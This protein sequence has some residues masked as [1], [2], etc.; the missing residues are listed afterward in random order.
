M[1]KKKVAKKKQA[2]KVAT[3]KTPAKKVPP[4]KTVKRPAAKPKPA[5]KKSGLSLPKGTSSAK[6]V[7]VGTK[8]IQE[9]KRKA[10]SAGLVFTRI[11]PGDTVVGRFLIDD[12]SHFRSARRHS[13]VKNVDGSIKAFTCNEGI[14]DSCF[15][16]NELEEWATTKTLL[17]FL[18]RTEGR[19]EAF[20]RGPRD[21]GQIVAFFNK[22]GTLADRDF[23][24]TRQGKGVNDTLYTFIPNDPEELD[25][26]SLALVNDGVEE[27]FEKINKVLTPT[28]NDEIRKWYGGE[29]EDYVK[30]D[31]I[32]GEK[33]FEKDE[34]D[35]SEKCVCGASTENWEEVE[36]EDG[37]KGYECSKCERLFDE[38]GNE[39]KEDGEEGGEEGGTNN[40]EILCPECNEPMPVDATK[41]PHC[42]TEFEDDF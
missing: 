2:K 14:E 1:A 15:L 3:K 39:V 24:A 16:C 6:G 11:D 29:T 13:Y 20:E 36:F 19:L 30:D 23:D 8:P 40:D 41:C 21:A 34:G 12:K 5:A 32:D 28:P 18:N 10:E 26:E 27:L 33:P 22:Y 7:E 25:D 35:D 4:K 37:S 9:A 31:D 42:G 17:P 38:G